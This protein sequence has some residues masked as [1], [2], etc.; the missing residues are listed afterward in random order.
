MGLGGGDVHSTVTETTLHI[1][2]FLV[3]KSSLGQI[4]NFV[5]YPGDY[6]QKSGEIGLKIGRLQT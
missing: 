2:D 3:R 1:S 5:N 6:R 4:A